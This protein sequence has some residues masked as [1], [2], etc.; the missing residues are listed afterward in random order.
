MDIFKRVYDWLHPKP[1]EPPTTTQETLIQAQT[2]IDS[3]L[4]DL[5]DAQERSG[6]VTELV[7][8]AQD[9]LNRNHFA[10]LAQASMSARARA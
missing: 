6:Q 4:K 8:R 7:A 10:E 2:A 1:V 9:Q 3:A 5:A